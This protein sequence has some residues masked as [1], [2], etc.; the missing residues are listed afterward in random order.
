MEKY[1]EVQVSICYKSMPIFTEKVSQVIQYILR[2]YWKSKN[3]LTTQEIII[4]IQEKQQ[5]DDPYVLLV[6]L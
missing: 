2:L 6:S 1:R 4:K 5:R 3:W